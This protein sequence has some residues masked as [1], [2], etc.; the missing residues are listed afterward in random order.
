MTPPMQLQVFYLLSLLIPK[1]TFIKISV[2]LWQSSFTGGGHQE[3]TIDLVKVTEKL[4]HI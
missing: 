3:K 4:Y 2:I 1:V